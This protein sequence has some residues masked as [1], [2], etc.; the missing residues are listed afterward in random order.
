[1]THVDPFTELLQD[2]GF[3]RTLIDAIPCGMFV[4]DEGG[5]VQAVNRVIERVFGPTAGLAVTAG[6]GDV[7]RCLD[8]VKNPG[9][10]ARGNAAMSVRFGGS[11]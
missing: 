10:A 11:L 6:S 7:L 8:A 3:A 9:D 5:R 1:M 4:M 2:S